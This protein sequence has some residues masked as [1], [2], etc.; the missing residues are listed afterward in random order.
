MLKGLPPLIMLGN[1]GSWFTHEAGALPPS[2]LERQT[3]SPAAVCCVDAAVD[4]LS[5]DMAPGAGACPATVS[6][7]RWAPRCCF[8]YIVLQPLIKG[9]S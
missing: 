5:S 7:P 1:A 4:V 3:I 9:V 8:T 6:Y 2:L